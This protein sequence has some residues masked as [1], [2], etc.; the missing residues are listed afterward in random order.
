M[1]AAYLPQLMASAGPP[2]SQCTHPELIR[3]EVIRETVLPQ[4]PTRH[5]CLLPLALC[6]LL[7]AGMKKSH[8]PLPS[9]GKMRWK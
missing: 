4:E 8:A 7:I 3:G 1:S 9:K 5:A 2:M 6:L